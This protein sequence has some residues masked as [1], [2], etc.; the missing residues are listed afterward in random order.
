MPHRNTRGTVTERRAHPC[1]PCSHANATINATANKNAGR[2]RPPRSAFHLVRAVEAEGFEPPG[3][4][5]PLAFKL[6][7]ATYGN[8]YGG[9]TAGHGWE[10][11]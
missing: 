2:G 9:T 8:S 1:Q 4:C 6:R 3:G 10:P 5:P 11:E 7:A